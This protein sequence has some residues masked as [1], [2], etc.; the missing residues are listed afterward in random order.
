MNGPIIITD[1]SEGL[2]AESDIAED[3]SDIGFREAIGVQFLL[4][5][6]IKV[7]LFVREHATR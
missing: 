7:I 1:V 4:I 5:L 2:P 3:I 6:L